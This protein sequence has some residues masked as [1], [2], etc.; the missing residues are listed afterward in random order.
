M[1][2][3]LKSGSFVG[4]LSLILLLGCSQTDQQKI[5]EAVEATLVALDSG[6]ISTKISLTSVVEFAVETPPPATVVPS[7]SPTPTAT[8]IPQPTMTPTPVATPTPEITQAFLDSLTALIKV[9]SDWI[10]ARTFEPVSG[11]RYTTFSSLVFSGPDSRVFTPIEFELS[12]LSVDDDLES[13]KSGLAAVF[14]AE[15]Q[16]IE[17]GYRG[18]KEV[19][20]INVDQYKDWPI[21]VNPWLESQLTRIKLYEIWLNL[22]KSKR[23]DASI[24]R[25]FE[26]DISEI[27]GYLR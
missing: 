3:F 5:D 10:Y 25:E 26:T 8:T 4:L 17:N 1:K 21:F 19:N 18:W 22:L 23:V 12:V 6:V 9:D 7:P 20:H 15:V 11:R 13:I 27:Y 2:L 24:I 16:A 14:R